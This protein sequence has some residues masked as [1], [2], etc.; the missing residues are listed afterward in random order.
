VPEGILNYEGQNF[1]GVVL[2]AQQEGGAK[3]ENLELVVDAVVQS[4]LGRPRVSS[5][6]GWS[7]RE[8][9]Y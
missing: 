6:D 4:G 8:G 7:R 2:W 1:I 3:L 5:G 9:V